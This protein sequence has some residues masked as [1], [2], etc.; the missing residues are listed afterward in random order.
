M[1]KGQPVLVGHHFHRCLRTAQHDTQKERHSAHRTEC[2]KSRTGGGDRGH[3]GAKRRCDHFNQ[4]GR[5]RDGYC[6]GAKG[7]S[8]SGAC[9]FSARNGMKAVG[10]T[11]SFVA[12]PD[13]RAIRALRA[14]IL[15]GR[16]SAANFR[17]RTHHGHHGTGWEWKRAA[18]RT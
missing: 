9:T 6:A 10:S 14:F 1:I 3:G 7:W 16:R 8:T 5:T 15:P 18:D 4:Y 11:T 13:G 17:R 12:G 2:Q